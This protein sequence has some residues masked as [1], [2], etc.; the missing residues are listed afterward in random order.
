[1]SVQ[2]AKHGFEPELMRYA[3]NRHHVLPCM[4]VAGLESSQQPHKCSIE[5]FQPIVA[6]GGDIG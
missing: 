5:T 4:L 3:G 6:R 2:S 1:M